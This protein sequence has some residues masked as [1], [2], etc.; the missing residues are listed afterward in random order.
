MDAD[1]V[2][3]MG[4]SVDPVIDRID[5]I[6]KDIDAMC[7]EQLKQHC[8]L[9]EMIGQQQMSKIREQEKEIDKLAEEKD[10]IDVE[11]AVEIESR[12]AIEK[13]MEEMKA[14]EKQAIDEVDR[15]MLSHG[16][17]KTDG[18]SILSSYRSVIGEF[19][20]IIDDL[21]DNTFNLNKMIEEFE[22]DRSNERSEHKAIMFALVS[23]GILM[24]LCIVCIAWTAVA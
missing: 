24:I 15:F 21:D 5:E 7:M 20:H 8:R 12:E 17:Q 4:D 3:V 11:L 13:R 9:L 6:A 23:F 1:K 18:S 10:A 16:F 2:F 14:S 22:A 19:K